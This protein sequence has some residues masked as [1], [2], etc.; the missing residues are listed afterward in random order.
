MNCEN[1]IDKVSSSTSKIASPEKDS[2][3]TESKTE[4]TRMRKFPNAICH[5]WQ[6]LREE[7]RY[8]FTLLRILA[9]LPPKGT[10]SRPG[11]CNLKGK[12]S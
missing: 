1:S 2:V 8:N 5:S 7:N 6:C 12:Q 10:Q 9:L 4:S 3:I 11:H